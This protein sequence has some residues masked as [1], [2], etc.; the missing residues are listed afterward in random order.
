MRGSRQLDMF[1]PAWA[2]LVFDGPTT[3]SSLSSFSALAQSSTSFPCSPPRFTI[4]LMSPASDLFFRWFSV[5]K[6]GNLLVCL[7]GPEHRPPHMRYGIT[8]RLL[9]R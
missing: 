4:Q 3:R 1:R 9:R 8:C 5:S 6:H 2:G 7:Q